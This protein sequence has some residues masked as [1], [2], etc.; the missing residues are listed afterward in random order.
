MG[1]DEN[2]IVVHLVRN[3][4]SLPL[5]DLMLPVAY[6]QRLPGEWKSREHEYWQSMCGQR[7]A[8]AFL[9]K[10]YAKKSWGFSQPEQKPVKNNDRAANRA[11]SLKRTSIY[12]GASRQSVVW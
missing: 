4:S 11:L 10:P 1:I 5:K 12:I 2:E 7:Q 3:G 6:L 8:K 9:Q